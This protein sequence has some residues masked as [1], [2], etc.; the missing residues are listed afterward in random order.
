MYFACALRAASLMSRT[1]SAN[2]RAAVAHFV[3]ASEYTWAATLSQP[4]D[5]LVQ[6]V[7]IDCELAHGSSRLDTEV[8]NAD[9]LDE[10]RVS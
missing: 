5:D 10:S 8:F 1:P 2:S 3:W 9:V 7:D 6:V 4:G